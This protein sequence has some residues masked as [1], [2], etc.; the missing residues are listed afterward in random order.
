MKQLLLFLIVIIMVIGCSHDDVKITKDGSISFSLS[1]K[2]RQGGRETVGVVPAAVLIS[3]NDSQGKVVYENKKLTLFSFGQGY[4]SETLQ[5]NVGN[6]KLTK[7]LV[8]D[9]NDKIIYA[10]PLEGSE[11]AKYVDDPL[12]INFTVVGGTATVTPQVLAVEST[13]KPESFGYVNFGFEIVQVNNE[14]KLD[15]M[16]FDKFSADCN[17]FL[18][19]VMY[20]F[21]YNNEERL[22]ELFIYKSFGETIDWQLKALERIEYFPEQALTVETSRSLIDNSILGIRE[23]H[24][25][26]VDRVSSIKVYNLNKVFLLSEALYSYKTDGYIV[27]ETRYH[28]DSLNESVKRDYLT[29]LAGNILKETRYDINGS[30]VS[31][32]FYSYDEKPNPLAEFN[33]F[34]PDSEFKRSLVSTTRPDQGLGYKATYKNVYTALGQLSESTKTESNGVIER[35]RFIY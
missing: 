16:Y 28:S 3:I 10:T 34:F 31:Q 19:R 21:K 2:P 15:T 6:Y 26:F 1:S 35:R 12:P 18:P 33:P 25:D 22:A 29:D 4:L 5:L 30:L 11:L 24:Y 9:V 23:V 7:F 32:F 17:C 13:D 8:L 27:T 14:Y 20:V